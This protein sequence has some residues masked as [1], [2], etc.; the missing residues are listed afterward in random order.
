[1]ID[2]IERQEIINTLSGIEVQITHLLWAYKKKDL[3]HILNNKG[4]NWNEKLVKF[5]EEN[6]EE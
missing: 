6:A 2:Y 5:F 1:M 4:M 3:M